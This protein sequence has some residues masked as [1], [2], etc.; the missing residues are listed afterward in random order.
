MSRHNRTHLARAARLL[1]AAEAELSA[2]PRRRAVAD[3]LWR[4]DV[5]ALRYVLT[6]AEEYVAALERPA[7]PRPVRWRSKS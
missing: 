3:P 2:D 4:R 6:L 5:L 1:A 7:S